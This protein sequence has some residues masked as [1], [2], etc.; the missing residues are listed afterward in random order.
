MV[1]RRLDVSANKQGCPLV[2]Y[3]KASRGFSG[4]TIVVAGFC[5]DAGTG[6]NEPAAS[7]LDFDSKSLCLDRRP[8]NYRAGG[9]FNEYGT[10]VAAAALQPRVQYDCLAV[11]ALDIKCDAPLATGLNLATHDKSLAAVVD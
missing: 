9:V 7:A 4:M 10:A 11:L 6:R 3:S 1:A 2:F 5:G 8:R